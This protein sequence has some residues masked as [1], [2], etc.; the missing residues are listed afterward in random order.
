MLRINSS[1]GEPPGRYLF[2]HQL[3]EVQNGKEYV[4][5]AGRR[6]GS[7]PGVL[8]LLFISPQVPRLWPWMLWMMMM[9]MTIMRSLILL[10][11]TFKG[12]SYS[13]L[14]CLVGIH[15]N[16]RCRNGND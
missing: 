2:T 9:V 8:W 6:P 14:L 13:I 12:P 11:N 15:K 7:A 1:F 4:L 16:P 3:E 5:R 10:F